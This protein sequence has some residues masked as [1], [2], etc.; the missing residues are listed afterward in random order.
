VSVNP[1]VIYQRFQFVFNL[2]WSIHSE[3]RF[4]FHYE[5][6][7]SLQLLIYLH[8]QYLTLGPWHVL[9]STRMSTID[10]CLALPS[11]IQSPKLAI[12]T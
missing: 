5:V 3:I 6:P 8:L 11:S 4:D 9:E 10:G 1:V 12:Y 7:E 2:H